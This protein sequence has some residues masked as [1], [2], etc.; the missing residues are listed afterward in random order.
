MKKVYLLLRNNQQSGPFTIGELLQQQLRSSDMIW[1]EGKSTAWTYLSELELNPHLHNQEVS[2]Q[3]QSAKTGDEI[4]KK[5]EELRQRI[6]TSTSRAFFPKHVVEIETYASPNN[7]PEEEIQ[8]IDHRKERKSKNNSVVGEL[9]LTCFVIGL[10]MLGIYKGPSFL[11][12]RHKAQNSVAIQLNS[13]D[14]HSA[15]KNDPPA[16]TV[17]SA[18]DTTKKTDSLLTI[19]KPKQKFSASK[20]N[21]I[22]STNTGLV[23]PSNIATVNQENKKEDVVQP[24]SQASQDN[25]IKKD[26]TPVKKEVVSLIPKIKTNNETGKEEKK[27]FLRGLFKKKKKED[28]SAGKER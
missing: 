20:K 2:D 19:Q 25:A 22:D 4:E 7:L 23:L 28:N 11:G 13:G 8:F 1:I 24:P 26:D 6:L 12:A 18:V 27:G 17:F 16:K 15:R 10:F 21:V 14:Q 5:A 3:S 9:L